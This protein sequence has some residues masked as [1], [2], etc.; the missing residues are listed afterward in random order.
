VQNNGTT[1]VMFD[2]VPNGGDVVL[3]SAGASTVNARTDGAA[4]TRNLA[5]WLDRGTLAFRTPAVADKGLNVSLYDVKGSCIAR[6]QLGSSESSLVRHV[7][8]SQRTIAP[9]MWIARVTDGQ[10]TWS[11]QVQV[12]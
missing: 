4:F 6:V 8:I 2:V 3:S 5:V 7:N 11:K 1:Y 9:G 12:F 10:R